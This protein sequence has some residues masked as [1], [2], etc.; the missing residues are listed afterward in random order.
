MCPLCFRPPLPLAR[1]RISAP[2]AANNGVLR[3]SP[4][5]LSNQE[6]LR[7]WCEG[8]G[9]FLPPSFAPNGNCRD[10]LLYKTPITGARQ[11]H[12][13]LTRGAADF[14]DRQEADRCYGCIPPQSLNNCGTAIEQPSIRKKLPCMGWI[15]TVKLSVK[16]RDFPA[17]LDFAIYTFAIL[18]QVISFQAANA[19][20]RSFRF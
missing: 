16:L 20:V 2:A 9:Q 1:P 14:R 19:W 13:F 7:I 3:H 6:L 8:S 4:I 12:T 10:S 15:G 17:D 5:T 11:T 18:A